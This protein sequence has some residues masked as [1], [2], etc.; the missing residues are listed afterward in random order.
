[1]RIASHGRAIKRG[2]RE[3]RPSC[4]LPQPSWQGVYVPRRCWF[5]P[6]AS[7][8]AQAS[9][10]RQN[11]RQA[12][13]Q[14]EKWGSCEPHFKVCSGRP[15]AGA[16]GQ[17]Q[18]LTECYLRFAQRVMS[19]HIAWHLPWQI[20]SIRPMAARSITLSSWKGSGSR[21]SDFRNGSSRSGFR[22]SSTSRD[23]EDRVDLPAIFAPLDH[24]TRCHAM[25][26]SKR[27]QEPKISTRKFSMACH[28]RRSAFAS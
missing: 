5:Q 17:N 23:W 15:A 4:R 9:L 13:Q 22:R 24:F 27:S 25:K 20:A 11:G 28:E 21:G 10:P 2:L 18:R 19:V 8:H 12:K 14:N 3:A 16:R 26:P 6:K 7:R 1:M